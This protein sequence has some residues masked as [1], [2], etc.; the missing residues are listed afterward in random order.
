MEALIVIQT[1]HSVDLIQSKFNSW[2]RRLHNKAHSQ[3]NPERNWLL[4]SCRLGGMLW[5]HHTDLRVGGTKLFVTKLN[6]ASLSQLL[7]HY[8]YSEW[9]WKK[10]LL[11]GLNN[12]PTL[13]TNRSAAWFRWDLCYCIVLYC[14][15]LYCFNNLRKGFYSTSMHTF[16]RVPLRGRVWYLLNFLVNK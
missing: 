3:K 1:K 2:V 16:R 6:L 15:V 11:K 13:N 7:R 14:T 5:F 4:K 10:G 8:T 12:D 9:S